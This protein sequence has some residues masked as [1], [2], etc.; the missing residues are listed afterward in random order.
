MVLVGDLSVTLDCTI[1]YGL[2]SPMTSC[3]SAPTVSYGNTA[4]AIPDRINA[5]PNVKNGNQYPTFNNSSPTMGV[6]TPAN[7]VNAEHTP[8]AVALMAVGY[9]SGAI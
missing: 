8:I 3:N 9:T 1:V 2:L 4:D 5:M 6:M 7:L